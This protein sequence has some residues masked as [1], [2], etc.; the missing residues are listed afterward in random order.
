MDNLRSIDADWQISAEKQPLT[1]FDYLALIEGI[2]LMS[3]DENKLASDCYRFAHTARAIFHPDG[4]KNKHE[5][6][7]KD[8]A[9]L[10]DKLELNNII[11]RDE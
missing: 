10:M 4:C 11:H 5:D 3:D 1:I 8:A 9:E 7:Q 2:C 6:W